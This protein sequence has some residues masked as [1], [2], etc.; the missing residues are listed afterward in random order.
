MSSTETEKLIGK[1]TLSEPEDCKSDIRRPSFRSSPNH[2]IPLRHVHFHRLSINHSQ[3]RTVRYPYTSNSSPFINLYRR[4]TRKCRIRQSI[5]PILYRG[6]GPGR[7]SIISRSTRSR[8][9][10]RFIVAEIAKQTYFLRSS[11]SSGTL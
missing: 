7:N 3:W 10:Y 11:M 9:V 5:S 2:E 6:N 4:T 1:L 8:K